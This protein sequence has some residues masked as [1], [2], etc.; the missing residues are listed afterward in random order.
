[1]GIWWN[2]IVTSAKL[3]KMDVRRKKC[4]RSGDALVLPHLSSFCH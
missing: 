3:G 2:V 4:P 1:M